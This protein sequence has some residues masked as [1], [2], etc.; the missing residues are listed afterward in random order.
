MS[1]EAPE[2]LRFVA[3]CI[4]AEGKGMLPG[5]LVSRISSMKQGRVPLSFRPGRNQRG[6]SDSPV[7]LVNSFSFSVL[8]DIMWGINI[9]Q[10]QPSFIDDL[11]RMREYQDKAH[12]TGFVNVQDLRGTDDTYQCALITHDFYKL[13]GISGNL[14]LDREKKVEFPPEMQGSPLEVAV[15]EL[16]RRYFRK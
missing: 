15:P 8:D 16:F 13:D 12:W 7:F 1:M 9:A 10:E 11:Y 2:F 14:Y 5:H 4:L 3:D 6:S